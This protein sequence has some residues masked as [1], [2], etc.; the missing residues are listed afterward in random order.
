MQMPSAETI[1]TLPDDTNPGKVPPMG[2]MPTVPDD[3]DTPLPGNTDVPG[4]NP[5][6]PPGGA[7]FPDTVEPPAG[8][9]Q[10]L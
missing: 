6:F 3:D 2:P 4:E 5:A 10:S 7:P 1:P 9:P 8:H